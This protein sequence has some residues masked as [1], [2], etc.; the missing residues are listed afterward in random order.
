LSVAS[1]RGLG[2]GSPDGRP[3][4][5]AAISASLVDAEGILN[6][7]SGKAL[8]ALAT[9]GASERPPPLPRKWGRASPTL[10]A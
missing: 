1:A 7:A 5:A 2:L 3:L 8:A 10:V 4:D 6:D 9:A